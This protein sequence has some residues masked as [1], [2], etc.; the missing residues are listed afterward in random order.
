MKITGVNIKPSFEG[1]KAVSMHGLTDMVVLAGRNGSGKSRILRA[2]AAHVNNHL[3]KEE[4]SEIRR[5]ERSFQESI[6][7][8]KARIDWLSERDE[9]SQSEQDETPRLLSSIKAYDAEIKGYQSKHAIHNSIVIDNEGVKPV[10]VLYQVREPDIRDHRGMRIEEILSAAENMASDFNINLSREYGLA[11]L[12][13]LINRYVYSSGDERISLGRDVELLKELIQEFLGTDLDWDGRNGARLFGFPIADA[14]LSDGQKVLLQVA[15]SI[16]FQDGNKEGL[17][18]LLDEPENH[19][20]PSA[21]IDLVSKIRKSCPSAQIWI[22]THSIHLLAHYGAD[23][24]WFVDE[25]GVEFSGGGATKILD[26]LLGGDEGADRLSEFLALPTKY[27]V[28]NFA[29]QCMLPPGV[30]DTGSRDPQTSQISTLLR[31]RLAEHRRMRVLD[32]GMGK[33]RLL[34]ALQAQAAADGSKLSD[35]VE[36]LGFD[37]EPTPDDEALCR[38]RLALAYS[39]EAG[40]YHAGYRSLESINSDSVDV[41]VMCNV[42]HEID[43]LDWI[44]ILGADSHLCRI[45]R[46]DGVLM[47]V[48]DQLLR[49]GER[50]HRF[51]FLVLDEFELRQL[52]GMQRE[53]A[54]FKTT[55][56]DLEKYRGRLRAHEVPA[57]SLRNVTRETRLSAVTALQRRA[58]EEVSHLQ[59]EQYDRNKARAFAFWAHQHVNA[60]LAL[61]KI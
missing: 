23:G 60:S 33:G 32:Y 16:F 4:L 59:G 27:A 9:L 37:Y 18:V 25:G 24:I 38:Q 42:L 46:N 15:F 54:S 17:I 14:K 47:V 26:S 34:S 40:L 51:G 36:Y 53:D 52:F 48:E 49:V 10:A 61:P 20:H 56:H 58:L 55:D 12:H 19:L 22:A 41:V 11:A 45:L 28:N 44:K 13:D 3:S 7:A 50:A 5:S 39:D 57:T 29:A 8:Y 35:I 1:L 31:R 2:I 6:A 21:V 30:S 43:P